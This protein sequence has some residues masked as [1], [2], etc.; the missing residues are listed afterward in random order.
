MATSLPIC[1]ICMKDDSTKFASVWY[2][3]CEESICN[4]CEQQHSRMKLTKNHQPIPI[5]DYQKL[6][7][8]VADMKQGCKV[9]NRKL[10]FYCLIH[11][12]PCC[13]SCV[14]QKHDTCKT[15]KPLSEVVEAVKSSAAFED[16]EERTKDISELICNLIKDKQDNKAR[17]EFQKKKNYFRSAKCPNG[18]N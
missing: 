2:A 5:D 4:D 10:E 14:S 7:S 3:E 1:A 9:H 12:E 15:L 8:S 6:P 16:L 17:I 13:L 11:N 18:N